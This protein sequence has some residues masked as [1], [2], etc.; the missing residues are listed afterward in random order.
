MSL[1]NNFVRYWFPLHPHVISVEDLGLGEEHKII[2]WRW[3]CKLCG[4]I[5]DEM[6]LDG[7]KWMRDEQ[8]KK[9]KSDN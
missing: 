1:L 7:I 2:A 5:I 8:K 6:S 3:K 9:Q 4:A